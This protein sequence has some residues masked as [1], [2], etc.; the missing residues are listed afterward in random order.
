MLLLRTIYPSLGILKEIELCDWYTKD[1]LRLHGYEYLEEVCFVMQYTGLKDKNGKEIYE[2]DIVQYDLAQEKY[3]SLA[4]GEIV[5]NQDRFEHS[6]YSAEGYFW[7][8][9]KVIGNIY[10][11]PEL[12]KEDTNG[13]ERV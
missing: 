11:N 12:L 7:D 10:E 9:M 13:K 1:Q 4:V 6:R 2:G 3:P 8:K 5:W